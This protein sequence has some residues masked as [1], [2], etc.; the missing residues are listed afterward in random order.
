MK[1]VKASICEIN[2]LHLGVLSV[3]IVDKFTIIAEY[4][5]DHSRFF[6]FVSGN[7]RVLGNYILHI[8]IQKV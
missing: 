5:M 6:F 4:L 8:D 2:L 7:W 3:V 1:L